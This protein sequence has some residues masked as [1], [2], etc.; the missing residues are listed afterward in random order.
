MEHK[1]NGELVPQGGGDSIRLTRSPLTLG[2]RES[3]DICLQ[4]PNVS[5]KH[6]ELTYKEG[7]WIL[8]DLDSTNGIKVNGMRLD[9]GAK[10]VLHNGDILTIAKRSFTIV[11]NE[12]GKASDVGEADEDLE[13]NIK[14]PLL[15]KAN[16][17][18]PPRHPG[19][20]KVDPLKAMPAFDD[21]DDDD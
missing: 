21:D 3:C 18:H 19:Q 11:Y 6:C 17:A 13:S 9:T 4:F 20:K 16:L 5:G 15:E 10:K 7:L 14:I 12:T 2:R 8:R 1:L